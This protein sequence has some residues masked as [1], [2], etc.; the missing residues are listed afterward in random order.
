VLN[1]NQ[2]ITG[3]AEYTQAVALLMAQAHSEIWIFDQDLRLGG[4]NSAQCYQLL[5]DF[6]ARN[7]YSKLQLVL[8]NT[9]FFETQCP[10]LFALLALYAH[11][12]QVYQAGEVARN[13]ADCFMV[14]D[15]QHYLKRF[16]VSQA[17]FKYD[18]TSYPE[19]SL[20]SLRFEAL[21]QTSSGSISSTTLGL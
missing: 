10:R 5:Y 4:F 15:K 20:L 6:F 3:E 17:R 8:Q 19:V 1:P 12:M 13:A 18:L 16:H 21:L 11:R 2:I 9:E 14:V 7:S